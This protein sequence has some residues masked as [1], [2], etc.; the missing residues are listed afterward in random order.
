MKSLTGEE[1]CLFVSHNMGALQ[2]LCSSG[3]VLEGGNIVFQ[4]EIQAA[5]KNHL[6]RMHSQQSIDLVDRNDRKGNQL[7]RFSKVIFFDSNG[8]EVDHILS[9]EDFFVRIYYTAKREITSAVVDVAFN[10]KTPSSY[11]ITNLNSRDCGSQTMPIYFKGYF[12]C[13]WPKFN[14][15]SGDYDCTLFCSINHDVA[16]WIQSAFTLHVD[17]GDYFGTG[18]IIDRS[19]GDILVPYSWTSKEGE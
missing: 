1:Q 15:R 17:D 14:L 12:E 4:G 13:R 5:I 18:K 8:N 3:I 16:D 19:Q 10:V 11:V 9:G 7:L 6:Q 2:N